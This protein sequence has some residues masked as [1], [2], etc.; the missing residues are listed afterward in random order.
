MIENAKEVGYAFTR[1]TN[2][3]LGQL[4]IKKKNYRLLI[5]YCIFSLNVVIFLN[6][7]VLL[8]FCV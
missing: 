3:D 7:A 5:K 2:M 1:L 4:S 6:S 8:Q